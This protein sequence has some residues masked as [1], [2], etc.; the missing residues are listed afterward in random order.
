LGLAAAGGG[1]YRR[2]EAPRRRPYGGSYQIARS[3]NVFVE[4][5]GKPSLAFRTRTVEKTASTDALQR[6]IDASAMM[7]VLAKSPS[8]KAPGHILQLR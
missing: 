8:R 1:T 2:E 7:L 4:D 6:T 3:S 5:V